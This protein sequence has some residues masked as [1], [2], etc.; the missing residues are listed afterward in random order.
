MERSGLTSMLA[1]EYLLDSG[2]LDESSEY[3]MDAEERGYC[4]ADLFNLRGVLISLSGNPRQGAVQFEKALVIAPESP[5]LWKNYAV[6]LWADARYE[7]SIE[8][9]RR[10]AN[11]NPLLRTQLR[12]I[13][14]HA[15]TFELWLRKPV[16]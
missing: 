3:L 4:G 16:E 7:D 14:E 15:E 5:T 11:L 13:L 9:A 1:A 12:P 6:S 10:A 2:K 8:A